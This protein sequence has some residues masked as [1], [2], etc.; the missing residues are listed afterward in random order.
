MIRAIEIFPVVQPQVW[1]LI[2]N[3]RPTSRWQGW[4]VP[5]EFKHVRAYAYVP[6]MHVWVFYDPHIT[7]TDIFLARDGAHADVVKVWLGDDGEQISMKL[8]PTRRRWFPCGFWCVPAIK[9]LLGLRCGALLV[10]TLFADCL[11]HGGQLFKGDRNENPTARASENPV[12][13]RS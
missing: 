9:H 7:A 2:F 3:R 6:G 4:L 10:D 1:N 12:S 11:L 5:G 8:Q 13:V